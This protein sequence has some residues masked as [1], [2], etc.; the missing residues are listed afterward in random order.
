[1]NRTQPG[2]ML[3]LWEQFRDRDQ[4]KEHEIHN[5]LLPPRGHMLEGDVAHCHPLCLH[6]SASLFLFLAEICEC[7]WELYSL[8]VGEMCYLKPLLFLEEEI[9]LKEIWGSLIVLA[10]PNRKP[11]WWMQFTRVRLKRHRD[12]GRLY[13][14]KNWVWR[15]LISCTASLLSL[16][17]ADICG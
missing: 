14:R 4:V 3:I 9:M 15:D 7:V 16:G 13:V 8:C 10:C 12:R 1:M 17:S 11:L 2:E 5:S 6:S